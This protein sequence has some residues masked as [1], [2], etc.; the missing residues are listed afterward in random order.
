MCTFL[1]KL[2]EKELDNTNYR[3][4]EPTH[5]A[6][7]LG[8][9]VKHANDPEKKIIFI[10]W[11][12]FRSKSAHKIVVLPLSRSMPNGTNNSKINNSWNKVT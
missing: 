5:G 7:I 1:I 10:Y 4:S 2:I 3:G 9:R 8:M 11:L 6:C 12:L